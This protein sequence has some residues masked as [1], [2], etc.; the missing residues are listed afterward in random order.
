MSQINEDSLRQVLAATD[1]VDL[2]GT[3]VQLKKNGPAFKGLCPFHPEKT[4]SF[5]VSPSRQSYHC[6]GCGKGGDSIS[7]IRDHLNMTFVEAVRHL[8]RR[9]NITLVEE[10]SDPHAESA[11][12]AKSRL[13]KI[14]N[15]AAKWMHQQL[16]MQGGPGPQAARD[17][18]NKR[19]F[20]KET[21]KRWLVGYAPDA[22]NLWR[23]WARSKGYKDED[24]IDSGLFIPR[25]EGQPQQG[26]YAR[27]RH[28]IMFPV[29]N[30]QGDVIAFSGRLLDPTQKGGKYINSPET[31]IFSKS[32]VLFGWDKT[33]RSIR[34]EDRVIVCE[35]QIDLITIFEHGVENVAAA[36]GTAFTEHHAKMLKRAASQVTLCYD[37]DD[38]GFKAAKKC[39]NLLAPLGMFIR[40]AALPTGEDPDSLIR[41]KGVEVFRERIEQAR[42][43]FDFQIDMH[44]DVMNPDKGLE[45]SRLAGELAENIVLLSDKVAQDTAINRCSTRL[46]LPSADLR[47]LVGRE[48]R[49]R[50]KEEENR[51]EAAE[52]FSSKSND[53]TVPASHFQEP[54]TAPL[55]ATLAE[56]AS[57][58]NW[59]LKHIIRLS[60]TDTET[61]NW[62]HEQASQGS[63]PWREHLGGE[64]LDRILASGFSPEDPAALPALLASMP[65]EYQS[66]LTRMLHD[67]SP[68]TDNFTTV[69][70]SF[71][72]LAYDNNR[73]RQ[74]LVAQKLRTPGTTMAEVSYAM[75]ELARLK[76]EEVDL[77][78][79]LP[80][81]TL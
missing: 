79:K 34:K 66:A 59:A 77:Q 29:R 56:Q 73:R 23:E 16:L 15:D 38:A 43:F 61:L 9:A 47:T 72:R 74:Q 18:W 80:T 39:F 64:L 53:L 76:R 78:Q 24:L 21:S 31:P 42:D 68:T 45:R 46:N 65:S 49:K 51:K 12:K 48:Q 26:G 41:T 19:G 11:H 54:V 70:G 37:A 40:V 4:P 3:Y 22:P 27:F 50:R 67:R 8:A 52:R 36:L 1:V 33:N 62:L 55:S 13:I 2:I 20:N 63:A 69:Q 81:L 75:Q 5:N 35:G 44:P 58:Q 30:D 25:V 32:H 6:F 14:H 60:L 57:I 10:A 28:R 71:Y 7:F 17:Y